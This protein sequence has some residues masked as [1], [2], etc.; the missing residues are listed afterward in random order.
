M[1]KDNKIKKSLRHEWNNFYLVFLFY[2]NNSI[3]IT[4]V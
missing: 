3:L 1:Q 2:L 4:I